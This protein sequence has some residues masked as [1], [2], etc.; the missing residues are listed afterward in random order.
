M[1]IIENIKISEDL[2]YNL[3]LIKYF[4]LTKYFDLWYN[5]IEL[6]RFYLVEL[7]YAYNLVHWGVRLIRAIRSLP[8]LGLQEA[9]A[10]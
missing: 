2:F 1:R 5:G 9:S 8:R 4:V 6:L 3:I 10:G 7:E